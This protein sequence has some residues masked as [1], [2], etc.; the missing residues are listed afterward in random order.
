[1][2]KNFTSVACIADKPFPDDRGGSCDEAA[3]CV[4]CSHDLIANCKAKDGLRVI[5]VLE[6]E[7]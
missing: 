4:R 3:G 6:N 2:L 7:D 5:T 1:M